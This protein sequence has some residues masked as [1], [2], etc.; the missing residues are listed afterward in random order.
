[1]TIPER[2]CYYIGKS[3]RM[4]YNFILKTLTIKEKISVRDFGAI[5]EIIKRIHLEVNNIIVEA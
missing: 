1:M 4:E 3:Y 2:I 5:K